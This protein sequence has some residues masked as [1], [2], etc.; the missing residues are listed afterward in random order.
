MAEQDEFNTDLQGVTALVPVAS[1]QHDLTAVVVPLLRGVL[2]RDD[3]AAVWSALL[4][5]QA[6]V[7]DY[8]AVLALELTVDEAEGYAFLRSRL[9]SE[10]DAGKLPRLIVRRQLSFSVSLL[11]ALLRKKLAAVKPG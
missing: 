9:V 11:L 6:R 5:L 2:Y 1:A 3:D 10:E 8:V 7:R 4:A